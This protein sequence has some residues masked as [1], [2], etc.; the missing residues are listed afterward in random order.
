MSRGG[1]EAVS[2]GNH[3][4]GG[5]K[6]TVNEAEPPKNRMRFSEDRGSRQQSRGR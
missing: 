4:L 6:L 2:Y 5:R 3:T 1:E